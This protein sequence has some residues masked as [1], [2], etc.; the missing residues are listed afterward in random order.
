MKARQFS[1]NRSGLLALL[2]SHLVGGP[3]PHPHVRL[4]LVETGGEN[5][6]L[7]LL[8]KGQSFKWGFYP[9]LPKCY[10]GVKSDEPLVLKNKQKGDLCTPSKAPGSAPTLPLPPHQLFCLYLHCSIV[11]LHRTLKKYLCDIYELLLLVFTSIS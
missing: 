5:F 11:I 6:L 2:K 3:Q 4:I 10:L 7:K 9:G 1:L 8:K